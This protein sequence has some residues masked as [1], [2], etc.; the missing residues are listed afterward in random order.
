M[1]AAEV[2]AE[3]VIEVTGDGHQSL[4]WPGHGF[5]LTVPAGAVP[6]GTTIS[7]AVK[8]ILTGDFEAA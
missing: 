3:T 7:L 4:S 1:L 5:R 2:L 6:M 8:S